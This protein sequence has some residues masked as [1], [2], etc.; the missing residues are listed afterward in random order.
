MA[1]TFPGQATTLPGQGRKVV[2]FRLE[3]VVAF[4]SESV[5]ALRPEWVVA[6]DRNTQ[7]NLLPP[8]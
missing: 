3:W 6:F 8:G 7:G 1:T 4:P 5:V 2:A